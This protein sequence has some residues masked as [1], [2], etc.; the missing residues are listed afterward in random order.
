MAD[1]IAA[2]RKRRYIELCKQQAI[3]GYS[4]PPEILLEISDLR[5][6][7]GA[8]EKLDHPHAVVDRRHNDDLTLDVHFLISTNSSALYRVTQLEGQLRTV[9]TTTYV[10]V[11]AISCL[12]FFWVGQPIGWGQRSRPGIQI[13]GARGFGCGRRCST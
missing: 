2:F 9:I 12:G 3:Q 6:E 11:I 4:T 7:F 1:E 5:K 8:I 10:M 13:P